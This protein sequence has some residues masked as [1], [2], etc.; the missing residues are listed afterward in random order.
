MLRVN[1]FS[2]SHLK[3]NEDV[4]ETSDILSGEKWE[5]IKSSLQ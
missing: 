1:T 3:N 2:G 4:K 5:Q